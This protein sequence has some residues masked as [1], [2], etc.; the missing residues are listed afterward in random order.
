MRSRSAL[1]LSLSFALA[2]CS[3]ADV[4]AGA[5]TRTPE[6]GTV[7]GRLVALGGPAPGAARPLSGTVKL[8]RTTDTTPPTTLVVDGNG[9]FSTTM[10]TGTYRAL[11]HSPSF[12]DG[13]YACVADSEITVAA[14]RT[15][16]VDVVC[17]M[18]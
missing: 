15:T 9:R 7:D 1:V 17:P 6:R 5:P 3:A 2:G 8:T 10:R 14:G 12:G 18:R 16:H 13:A 4:S 11:G